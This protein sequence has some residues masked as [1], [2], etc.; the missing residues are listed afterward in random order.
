[1]KI[2][3]RY[4]ILKALF[5]ASPIIILLVIYLVIDPFKVIRTYSTYYQSGVPDYITLDKDYVSSQTFLNNV[6]TY[7]YDSYILGDSRS[8]VFEIDTWKKYI[9]SDKCYHFDANGETLL[10]INQKVKFLDKNNYNLKNV[11]ITLDSEVL[12]NVEERKSLIFFSHPVLAHKNRIPFQL[13]FFKAFISRDFFFKYLKFKLL[14]KNTDNFFN[15]RPIDY[16]VIRN[17]I[18]YTYDEKTI[19]TNPSE[20]Y[21]ENKMKV[22]FKRDSIQQYIPQI[23]QEKQLKLLLEIAN[24]FK[25]R[26]TN[27]KIIINPVYDQRRLNIKDLDFLN[28]IF[29]KENVFD[30]SGKNKL[31]EDYHNYYENSHYRPQV[32]KYI[33]KVLY[34]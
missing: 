10:G 23:I 29:G 24:I 7:N 14:H 27:Y 26:K 30:F 21:D 2:N 32:A 5:L 12:K 31:T 11:I 18:T 9:H 25:A 1:M 6:S 8:I 19:N 3:N 15:T 22:F 34:K 28:N 16:N 33:M 17:E 4:F 20:F 13:E